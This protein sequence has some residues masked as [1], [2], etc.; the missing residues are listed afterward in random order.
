MIKTYKQ[1]SLKK[2]F[3]MEIYSPLKM[4]SI[5]K[6]QDLY[7]MFCGLLTIVKTQAKEE[8]KKLQNHTNN[9]YNHLLNMYVQA[10]K[11]LNKYKSLYFSL[12]KKAN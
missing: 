11:N 1:I 12:V 7:A 8:A 9:A 5:I 2:N 3:K 10:V 6:E 4:P